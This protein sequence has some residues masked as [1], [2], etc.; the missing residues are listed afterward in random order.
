MMD[1]DRRSLVPLALTVAL[2]LLVLAGMA[3][4]AVPP[5][6]SA[7]Y[8][9][10]PEW[11]EH[12]AVWLGWTG[13]EVVRE[14]QLR[15]ID[16][17]IAHV[18]ITL[19]VTSEDVR[20]A[21]RD[22]LEAEGF[23][24]DRIDF[25]IHPEWNFFI[26]DAGPRF[27]TDGAGLAVADFAWSYYG[28]PNLLAAGGGLDR[29][30]VDDDLAREMGL[31][32]VGSDVVAEGGALEVSNTAILTYRETAVQRNPGV[33]PEE[34]EQ[35]YL[36]MYGKQQVIWLDRSP[37]ADKVFLGPKIGNYFGWGANGHVDEYV[38]F[39]DDSTILVARIDPAE[40][41]WDPLSRV[42]YD[43]LE[44]NLAELRKAV[45]V[46]GNPFRI[47]TLPV[48][49]LRHYVRTTQLEA[50]GSGPW[51]GWE[52][53]GYLGQ[54]TYRGFA[55]GDE[56][57]VV[58][59]LSYLNFFVTNGVVLAP[60]YWREGLPEREREKDETV[61]ATLQRLFPDREIVQI[62]PLPANWWGGG[63]HCMTQQQPKVP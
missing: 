15:M 63:M 31:P 56:I 4:A 59:A 43:I 24:L 2:T 11:D 1:T 16:A 12:D 28:Y 44:E 60:A 41:D 40:K 62:R 7:S 35:E 47:V 51:P 3:G 25:R 6:A 29:G 54:A 45:D 20:A 21:A 32:L 26:R 36:R 55:P 30:E 5:P 19:L 34:I 37:L 49:A 38:R 48:P 8:S 14:L 23:D 13:E 10:P 9:F 50:D 52:M 58:P 17:M 22:V 61:R 27:L 53:N 57:H 42:D 39:V 18:R 46:N 33:P